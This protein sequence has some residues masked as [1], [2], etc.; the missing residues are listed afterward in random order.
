MGIK[1]C[2]LLLICVLLA[3]CTSK[4]QQGVQCQQID[5]IEITKVL[6]HYKNEPQKLLAASFLLDNILSKH[7][8]VGWQIDSLKKLK[9]V[10]IKEGRINDDVVA[11][12]RNFDYTKLP[13]MKDID[14]ITAD[15]LIENIDLAFDVWE[16]RPWSK[17]YSFQDFC[18]YILPYRI[19]DEP[20]EKWRKIYYERYAPVLDSLY[21]GSDVV[22]AARI[23]ANYLKD[24]GFANY[25][26]FTLPH[27]GAL[28]LLENRVG[29]CRENCDI[30]IYVMRALGIPVAM[31]FYPVSPSYNSL[32]YWTA[33]IDTTH[34]VIPFNYIET[35]VSRQVRG[36]ERKK[37]KVYRFLYG[38][39]P[40]KLPGIY[41]SLKIP[42]L[43]K[44]S[45][46]RDVS[47]EYFP[48]SKITIT[49]E[50]SPKII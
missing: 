25:T 14:V 21:Q 35:E 34:L 4:V 16:K 2:I 27:L 15:V 40:E 42:E 12:W 24:E 20:L 9:I 22:L 47:N 23:M 5:S 8:Y 46:I 39:Q 44:D 32:H 37:G 6:D 11:E 45:F 18:E 26:D 29:Y 41:D 1:K 31:D 49:M 30:A 13:V 36:D 48:D 28:F 7:S 3:S 17:H 33:L 10:S 38:A 19:G 50:N 43:F